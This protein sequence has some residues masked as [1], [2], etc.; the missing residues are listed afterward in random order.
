MCMEHHDRLIE[1]A[2]GRSE[3]SDIMEDPRKL[4]PGEIDPY[5]EGKPAKPDPIDMDDD[6]LYITFIYIFIK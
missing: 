6:G 4:R 5:P 2:F 1:S 3:F